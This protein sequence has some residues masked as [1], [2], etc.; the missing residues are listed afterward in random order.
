M[1]QMAVREM[2]PALTNKYCFFAFSESLHL[3]EEKRF[4]FSPFKTGF[5]VENLWF[6][7]K[8]LLTI[9]NQND[10]HKKPL[11][12]ITDQNDRKRNPKKCTISMSTSLAKSQNGK[13]CIFWAVA[14]FVK[15]SVEAVFNWDW[16][17]APSYKRSHSSAFLCTKHHVEWC[18][19][20]IWSDFPCTESHTGTKLCR[21]QNGITWKSW[22]KSRCLL[23]WKGRS[24]KRSAFVLANTRI[25]S[26]FSL[27]CLLRPNKHL[28]RKSTW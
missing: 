4:H 19:Y 20:A 10:A 16:I 3:A 7:Q 8:L 28:H 27:Y 17:P 14:E 23:D 25:R 13:T 26:S 9:V 22:R 15:S 6:L 11:P 1:L 2:S 12:V 18:D 5:N 21:S 24:T